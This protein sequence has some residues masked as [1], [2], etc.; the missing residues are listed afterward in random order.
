[1]H[2]ARIRVDRGFNC[3]ALVKT[4]RSIRVF[5]A[6]TAIHLALT[7]NSDPAGLPNHSA[8]AAIRRAIP[9]AL[10]STIRSYLHRFKKQGLIDQKASYWLLTDRGKSG[11]TP[12]RGGK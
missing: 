6:W 3:S 10:P 1:M 5:R 8:H 9:S 12:D 2:A 7:T 4:R 11:A